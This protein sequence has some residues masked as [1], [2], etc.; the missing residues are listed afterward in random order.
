L[1][2]SRLLGTG[3]W[4]LGTVFSKFFFFQIQRIVGTHLHAGGSF[5]SRAKVALGRFS[6][7]SSIGPDSALGTGQNTCPAPD[8]FVTILDDLPRL[9]VLI[10]GSCYAGVSAIGLRTVPALECKGY[11]TIL[12]YRYPGGRWYLFLEGFDDVH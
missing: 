12:L 4:V 2:F 1:A 9:F 6:W 7:T 10:N 8:T 3:S 11:W 5:P